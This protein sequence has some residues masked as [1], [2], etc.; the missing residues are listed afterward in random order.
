MSRLA[1]ISG[2]MAREAPR[3]RKFTLALINLRIQASGRVTKLGLQEKDFEE[4]RETLLDVVASLR[5]AL[6]QELPE[7]DFEPLLRRMKKGE[8]SMEDWRKDLD[9][10]AIELQRGEPIT[11]KGFSILDDVLKLIDAEFTEGLRY[12]YNR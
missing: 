12:L 1:A 3:H 2:K 9:E 8:K 11:D 5:E 6:D 7:R 10:V 4:S